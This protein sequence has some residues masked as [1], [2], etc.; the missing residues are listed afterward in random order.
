MVAVAGVPEERGESH[1]SGPLRDARKGFPRVGTPRGIL[2]TMPGEAARTCDLRLRRGAACLGEGWPQRLHEL[3][4]LPECG[5]V[6]REWIPGPGEGIAPPLPGCDLRGRCRP[7]P[8]RLY[9]LRAVIGHG[10][11]QGRDLV[12]LHGAGG[13]GSWDAGKRA[14]IVGAGVQPE[15]FDLPGQDHRY[16]GVD[17]REQVLAAV[18]MMMMMMMMAHDGTAL[19]PGSLHTDHSPAKAKG[20]PYLMT[21]GIGLLARP[22]PCH[23]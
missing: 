16:P 18:V 4:V 20:S 3:L 5:V 17:G 2:A 8:R 14:G 10:V 6:G 9:D 21:T 7:G 19:P 1:R 12:G 13:I 23:S 15:P 11:D 22:T